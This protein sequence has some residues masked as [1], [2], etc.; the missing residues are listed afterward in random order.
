MG[1]AQRTVARGYGACIVKMEPSVAFRPARRTSRARITWQESR[2][3][4]ASEVPSGFVWAR[5]MPIYPPGEDGNGRPQNG[6][7]IRLY[8]THDCFQR[9]GCICDGDHDQAG[10]HRDIVGHA[11]RRAPHGTDLSDLWA[12]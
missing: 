4:I 10:P 5:P 7:E 6:P 3:L 12:N 2:S 1:C 9:R 11:P 8:G